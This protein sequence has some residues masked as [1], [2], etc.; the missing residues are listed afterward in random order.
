[1]SML[2]R[3]LLS[4]IRR[5]PSGVNSPLTCTHAPVFEKIR[6]VSELNCSIQVWQSWTECLQHKAFQTSHSSWIHSSRAGVVSKL[7]NERYCKS[8]YSI[9]HVWPD[10]NSARIK[11]KDS[12]VITGTE[13]HSSALKLQEQWSDRWGQRR[14]STAWKC[15]YIPLLCHASFSMEVAA[16]SNSYSYLLCASSVCFM[17]LGERV[18]PFWKLT[19]VAIQRMIYN[20]RERGAYT[21]VTGRMADMSLPSAMSQQYHTAMGRQF[22]M[23]SCFVNTSEL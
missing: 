23:D 14:Q 12:V 11:F 1:M 21:E 6:G 13:F 16:S 5:I 9:V 15:I 18:N 3:Y 8:K 22:C 10:V 7:S 20:E 17:T 4:N 19:T 2:W